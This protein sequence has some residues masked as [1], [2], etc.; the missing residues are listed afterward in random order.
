MSSSQLVS[1]LRATARS[2]NRNGISNGPFGILRKDS[3]HQCGGYSCDIVCSGQGGGQRQWDV[4][5]DA[6]GDQ[7]PTWNG[8]KRPPNIRIDVCEIQ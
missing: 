6:E 5:A 8:P 3:G 7:S 4:L 2:L 1:F